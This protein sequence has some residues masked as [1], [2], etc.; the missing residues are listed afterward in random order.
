MFNRCFGDSSPFTSLPAL[1]Q[2]GRAGSKGVHVVQWH[3]PNTAARCK[4]AQR[5]RN[6]CR[7]KGFG[8]V[9]GGRRQRRPET[10]T[11]SQLA[12]EDKKKKM[13]TLKK[14]CLRVKRESKNETDDCSVRVCAHLPT[15]DEGEKDAKRPCRMRCVMF[16][17]YTQ[18]GKLFF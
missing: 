11:I 7:A 14:A 4:H 15:V 3:H 2:K 8:G 13:G 10:S 5:E 18:P 12:Q 16:D 17:K 1:F 9:F 6:V